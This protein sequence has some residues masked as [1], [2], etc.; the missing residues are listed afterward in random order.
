[1]AEKCAGC[2]KANECGEQNSQCLKNPGI[3]KVIAVMS[4]KGGVGKSSVTGLLALALNRQGFRVGIMDAD[5]TGPSI[6]RLFG[7][8]SGLTQVQ[9]GRINP[10]VTSQGIKVMSIN[11]LL[12]DEEEPVIWRGPILANVVNQFWAEVEWG[13]LDYLLVDLP[14]GTGDVPLTVMQSLPI[15]GMIVVTSPQSLVSM[16][17]KKAL[18]MADKMGIAVLGLVE[19]MVYVQ[20]PDCGKKLD[21]FGKS[22]SE[23]M[24]RKHGVDILGRL[25]I[26]MRFVEMS[27]AGNIEKYAEIN[28][29]GLLNT[30]GE[31][32][33]K[34]E[35]ADV[36]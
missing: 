32:V 11:L 12:P 2:D 21:I 35:R 16:I 27:D 13:E 23:E 28:D 22:N 34:L 30:F 25:P 7:L 36:S 3:K 29:P 33:T 5:I 10:A 1:M 14:P 31:I 20:C 6:P 18:N 24:A 17:V 4:G 15:G 26:D 8:K 19:N 9:E